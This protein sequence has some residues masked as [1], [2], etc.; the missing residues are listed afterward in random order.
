MQ[1]D[2]QPDPADAPTFADFVASL[3]EKLGQALDPSP[4]VL[5]VEVN[6]VE[7]VIAHHPE[8]WGAGNVM[9]ACDFGEIPPSRD[10]AAVLEKLLQ[11]NR[12]LHGL[13]SPIFAMDPTNARIMSMVGLPLLGLD[14]EQ[15]LQ[16][17]SKH[18][19]LVDTWRRSFFLDPDALA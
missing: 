8:Q 16:T 4:G 12:D 3:G 19:L 14:G 1:V 6:G 11:A 13:W 17:L 2:L 7:F 9:L 10:R 15:A 18:V 5:A